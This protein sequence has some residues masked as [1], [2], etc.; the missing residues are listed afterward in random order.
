MTRDFNAK[1]LDLKWLQIKKFD[2]TDLDNCIDPHKEFTLEECK[3]SIDQHSYLLSYKKSTPTVSVQSIS[4]AVQ[5]IHKLLEPTN[6][7]T[8]KLS[9]QNIAS[10]QI[11]WDY[12][13]EVHW[14]PGLYCQLWRR[15]L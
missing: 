4:K 6:A 13:Q 7:L 14:S 10:L 11:E 2:V 8:D 15:S 12:L 9:H 3:E 5:N 1:K